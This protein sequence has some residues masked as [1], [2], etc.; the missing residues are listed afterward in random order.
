[1]TNTPSERVE[2][3]VALEQSRSSNA[4]VR[5]AAVEALGVWLPEVQALDRLS[6]LLEDETVT[7]EVDAAEALVR[8]GGSRGLARVLEELG[9]RRDDPDAD[10]MAYMLSDLD[11][12]GEWPVLAE[13]GRLP[14]DEVTENVSVGLE[15]LR[16]LRGE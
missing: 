11:A 3:A 9:R 13:A 15:N 7:V 5:L 1:M 14:P 16:A 8:G 12:A 10:Y 2:L 4:F 6:E